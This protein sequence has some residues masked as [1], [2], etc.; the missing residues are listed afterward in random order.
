MCAQRQ[1]LI[2]NADNSCIRTTLLWS[3][4]DMLQ[5]YLSIYQVAVDL[6]KMRYSA[7]LL[8]GSGYSSKTSSSTLDDFRSL[9]ERIER[10]CADHELVQTSEFAKRILGRPL[11][12]FDH[13]L[14][15]ELNHLDDSLSTE[16]KKEALLRVPPERVDYFKCDK[17]FG[18]KVDAAFPSCARDI[19][20]AG[21]CYAVAQE[22]G[23]VHHLMLVLERELHALANNFQVPY[24]RTNWQPIIDQ[25]GARLKSIPK[26]QQRDFFLE[27]TAQFGFLK[28]AYRNHSQHAHD[29]PY[30]MEKALSIL[31]HVRK[32]MKELAEAGLT[33]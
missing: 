15:A 24:Q 4:W 30:D 27:V 10:A 16:L 33:E 22:D 6:G 3:L 31:S 21:E 8:G 13:D 32:F 5:S 2:C 25:I 17:L 12:R 14:A 7:S 26:G 11:P 18:K 29:D 28:D 23:C 1:P 19:Q 20:K 9:V